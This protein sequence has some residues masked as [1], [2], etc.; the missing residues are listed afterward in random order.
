MNKQVLRILEI[1]FI[2]G[3][4]KERNYKRY[5]S[6]KETQHPDFL[7][8]SRSNRTPSV[9]FYLNVIRA[10]KGTISITYIK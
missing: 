8:H 9:N 4:N 6:M 1:C 10:M 2:S 7:E 5:I 3:E